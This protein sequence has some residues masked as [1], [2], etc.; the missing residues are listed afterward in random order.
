MRSRLAL[1]LAIVLDAWLVV[2]CAGDNGTSDDG[3]KCDGTPIDTTNVPQ[4]ADG[5][6][7][8]GSSIAFPPIDFY[9]ENGRPSGLDFDLG[10][11]VTEHLCVS[12]EVIDTPF[13]DLIDGVT[14][15]RFDV[16]FSAMTITDERS[17]RVDFIPYADVGSSIVVRAGNPLG[18]FATTDL[19]GKTVAV[20][21][22]TIHEDFVVA[23]SESCESGVETRSSI[24]ILKFD[25]SEKAARD[26]VTAGSDATLTDFP[27]AFVVA[28]SDPRL[29]LV[30][31][32][33]CPRPYGIGVRK[34]DEEL[35]TAIARALMEVD[36]SGVYDELM[37]KWGLG[38]AR[39]ELSDVLTGS[40]EIADKCS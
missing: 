14:Q 16:I 5:V 31:V 10:E 13:E 4:L 28:E 1:L 25:D 8:I 3:A 22:S 40:S 19:C 34:G 36:S 26:V 18:I 20:Q 7:S 32:Q 2:G 27:A 30:D 29:E 24:D 38:Q 39:L 37:K 6:L 17:A 12:V 15:R 23:Q 9:D 11:A 35:A 33:I 21:S